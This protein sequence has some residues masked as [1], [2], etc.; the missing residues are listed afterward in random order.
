MC[1]TSQKVLLKSSRNS[2]KLMLTDTLTAFLKVCKITDTRKYLTLQQKEIG[3]KNSLLTRDGFTAYHS[4]D[5]FDEIFFHCSVGKVTEFIPDPKWNPECIRMLASILP[6]RYTT[7]RL[8]QSRFNL[9]QAFLQNEWKLLDTT[10]ELCCS[11][12]QQNQAPTSQDGFREAIDADATQILECANGFKFGRLFSDPF[13]QGG[14]ELY[15]A[16]LENSLSHQVADAVYVLTS[17]Q[18][19][20]DGLASIR[21][22]SIGD[23]I[24]WEIPLVCKHPNSTR[25]HVAVDLL[26][27]ICRE[28]KQQKIPYVLIGTQG[29]NIGALRSYI[30]AGFSPIDTGVTLRLAKS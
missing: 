22:R 21:A 4:A 10:V 3:E 25:S 18:E 17:D 30:S 2:N 20:I 29:E 26:K 11:V 9:I 24:Y 5:A 7:I 13:F 6:Y 1:A 8:S 15:R 12:R 23:L 16:W 27:N 14:H 19:K 28:A